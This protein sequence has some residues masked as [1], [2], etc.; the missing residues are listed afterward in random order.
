MRPDQRQGVVDAA[1][2]LQAVRP[3]D[4]GEIHEYVEGQPHPAAVRQVLRER[5]TDLGLVERDDGRF[6]PVDDGP[7]DVEFDGVEALPEHHARTVEELFAEAFG[8]EWPDGETG[9]RLRGRIREVKRAYLAGNPPEYDEL[10]AL[11]YAAY[12]LPAT[13]AASQ[14]VLAGLAADDLLPRRLRVL[15]VGAGVGGPALGLCDLLPEDALVDYRAVEPGAGADILERLLETTG[16]NVH[17]TIHRERAESFDPGGPFDLVL[18]ANVL[19]ELD[20]P[21]SVVVEYLDALA[22]DGSL[23]A[24][25]PADRE[26][27]TGLRAVERGVEAGT[28]AT[29]YAPTLRLWPGETPAGDCWSFDRRPDLRVPEFQRRLDD[30]E[31]AVSDPDRSPGDG[32]FRN[33]DVQYAY[34]VLRTDG[35]E[36]VTVDPDPGRYAPMADTGD[37]VTERI[38]CLG[39]KLSR[40][41]GGENPLFLIGDGSERIDHFG[42][43]VE[44]TALNRAVERADYGTVLQFENALA[45]WNDDEGAYNLVI[46]GETIVDPVG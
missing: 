3:I 17:A 36:R 45:L 24:I 46:D 15:D 11:G 30:G 18:F 9:D 33:A 41:L 40:D 25:A 38:D 10:T 2:Y 1:R 34:G 42:V 5:A 27:A 12:H 31:R 19:S 8:P 37:H 44:P 35:R 14:Y 21:V 7:A 20:D 6:V 22:A 43:V 39:V 23:V 32:E 29:V 16:H 4:P 28:D 26:T 13:Y